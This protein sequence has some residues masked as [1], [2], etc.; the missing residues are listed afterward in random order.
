MYVQSSRMQSIKECMVP[1]C[2]KIHKVSE[3]RRHIDK[4]NNVNILLEYL[5]ALYNQ[6]FNS[7]YN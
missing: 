3:A 2:K 5:H 1:I 4:I 7:W 6:E